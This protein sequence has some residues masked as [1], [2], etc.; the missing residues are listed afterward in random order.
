MGTRQR[1]GTGVCLPAPVRHRNLHRRTAHTAGRALGRKRDH[2]ALL[3]RDGCGIATATVPEQATQQH[4]RLRHHDGRRI[5]PGVEGR[6]G[7]AFGEAAEE[8][9]G[10]GRGQQG[11]GLHKT[12]GWV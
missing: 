2:S 9:G 3:P 10:R 6:H 11:R 4:S 1:A 12:A 7:F 5:P 8:S